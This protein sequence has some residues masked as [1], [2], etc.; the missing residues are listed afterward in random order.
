[1]IKLRRMN[2]PE[3]VRL[4]NE[5]V[6]NIWRFGVTAFFVI[7]FLF[8]EVSIVNFTFQ[9]P[10]HTLQKDLANLSDEDMKQ[11]IIPRGGATEF[12]WRAYVDPEKSFENRPTPWH[13]CTG[14]TEW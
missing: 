9:Q 7:G 2:N 6:V 11:Y 10:R 5:A 14:D 4:L 12:I 8:Y 13:F 3:N 1:M